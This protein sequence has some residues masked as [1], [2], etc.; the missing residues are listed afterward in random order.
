MA[1]GAAGGTVK[2]MNLHH[3]ANLHG[4][5]GG[6]TSGL[7][8]SHWPADTSAAALPTTIGTI[9]Q[10]AARRAPGTI[11]LI[12]G[13][14][15]PARR[16]SWTYGELLAAAEQTARALLTR[17]SPGESVAVWSANC[18]EWLVLEFGTAL[19]GMILVPVNPAFQAAELEH[20]LGHSG[21]S[22]I[23]LAD[24][25]R[26]SDLPTIL[27]S[28]R[29]RLPRLRETISLRD[30]DAFL[31]TGSDATVLPDVDPDS[32]A[33]VLYTSGTTGRPKGAVLTH[34]GL[35]NNA[36]LACAAMGMRTGDVSL[37][38]MPLFH[39]A[40]CGLLALGLVQHDA[41]AVVVPYFDP[42]L[43]LELA[44]AYASAVIGGVPTMLQAVLGHP[45]LG[46]RDLSSL[47]FG[48]CGGASVPPALVEAFEAAL[49]IPLLITYA[50]TETCCSITAVRP[51]DSPTDRAETV[52]RPLPQAEVRICGLGHEE[53][54][55]NGTIG[56][57][58]VRGYLVMDGYLGDAAATSAAITSPGWLRTGDLG[59]M[60]E[61]GY[62]RIAGRVKEMIIRGGENIY[63]R[64]IE[65]VLVG[66]PA[67]AEA[68]VVPVASPFWGEEVGAVIRGAGQVRPTPEELADFCRQRL[69]A[70][71]VPAH[72]QVVDSLPCTATGKVRKDVLSARFAMDVAH[73]PRR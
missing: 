1:G 8:T 12:D 14:P 46:K 47:R 57:I 13:D 45:A 54:V 42:G 67:V 65:D 49:G 5:V 26:S 58:C 25:Y 22:G 71:K 18:P 52:G 37:N 4:T 17:F 55:P 50:Q 31:V 28:V 43:V 59:S 21:T 27:T 11:A 15:D 61:R 56:E 9:L 23:F 41:T 51:D 33:Q 63:P 30:L 40:G 35:T 20:V 3:T 2:A 34:R 7:A 69:A 10:D 36:R 66:H 70:F 39:I 6:E 72:W 68:A 19:A 73:K 62:L 29:D 60:D 44:E 32:P 64:E 48:I 16:R 38:P 53:T 24:R